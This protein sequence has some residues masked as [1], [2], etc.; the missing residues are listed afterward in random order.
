MGERG[1]GSGGVQRASET[2]GFGWTGER[3]EAE[4]CAELHGDAARGSG[5]HT[6]KLS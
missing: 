1:E 6:E 2:G 5:G 4:S 3:E